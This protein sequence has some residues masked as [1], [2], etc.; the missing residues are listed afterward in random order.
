MR[1]PRIDRQAINVQSLLVESRFWH[2]R[3]FENEY[4]CTEYEYEY[5]QPGALA[6]IHKIARHQ[7]SLQK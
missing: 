6:C 7:S 2:Q 1:R 4:R 3:S 5:A